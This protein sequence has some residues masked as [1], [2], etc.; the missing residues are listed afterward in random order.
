MSAAVADTS[1]SSAGATSTSTT[2]A[3]TAAAAATSLQS[4]RSLYVGGLAEDVTP[5]TLRAALVPFGPIKSIDVPM[6]YGKG[7]HKG[8]AF[9]EF[10]ESEDAAEAIYNLDG[11]ELMGRTLTV[12]LARAA[13][14]VKLGSNQ[15]VWSQDEWFQNQTGE[16]EQA[17]MEE[18]QK[19]EKDDA[20]TMKER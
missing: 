9:V 10:E 18:K 17:E 20:E 8:F 1:S 4:N 6:D 5:I 13:G 19:R 7:T 12:N 14:Q 15:A 16:K 11:S 2:A 3:A